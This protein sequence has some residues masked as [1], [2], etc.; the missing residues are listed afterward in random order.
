[1]WAKTKAF[2]RYG[3]KIDHLSNRKKKDLKSKTKVKQVKVV[4]KGQNKNITVQKNESHS[5]GSKTNRTK[6]IIVSK[7]SSRM[8]TTKKKRVFKTAEEKKRAAIKDNYLGPKCPICSKRAEI[9]TA[10]EHINS[11]K[12]YCYWVCPSC[13]DVSVTTAKGTYLPAGELAGLETR[14]LRIDTHRFLE[15]K[16]EELKFNN[17]LLNQ[18]ISD[19]LVIEETR[20]WIG[21][22]TKSELSRIILINQ[23]EIFEDKYSYIFKKVEK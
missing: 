8:K 14:K 9:K 1:M 18:W 23:K 10:K 2:F 5:K 12:N 17:Q 22:L 13:K 4:K 16:K 3:K 19:N 7:K 15:N 6:E 21:Q 20:A 11:N